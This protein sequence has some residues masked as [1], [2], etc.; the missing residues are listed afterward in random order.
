MVKNANYACLML[1]KSY[2]TDKAMSIFIQIKKTNNLTLPSKTHE[3]DA[4]YD[5]TA[6][7]D[8]VIIG[9]KIDDIV[10]KFIDYI[11]YDTGLFVNPLSARKN[12]D[13]VPESGATIETSHYHIDIRPRSSISKYNLILAN[14]VALIDRN[15]RGSI[16][17][18]FKYF[19]QPEDYIINKDCFF[20]GGIPNLDKIYKKG[21]KIGQ[22]QAFETKDIKFVLVDSLSETKRNDGGFGSTG[23]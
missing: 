3:E 22:L 19:W 12:I 21:D 16:K 4:G 10:Y 20:V 2:Y 15:Y 7:S 6:I 11:E 14:S 13:K 18:R 1:R 8:P 17:L 23:L 5:I 9:E